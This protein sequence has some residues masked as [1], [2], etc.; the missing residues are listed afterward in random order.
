MTENTTQEEKKPTSQKLRQIGQK[1]QHG[2][3][4]VHRKIG[5]YGWVS[6]GLLLLLI[7]TIAHYE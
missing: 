6:I 3:E 7:A 1:I 4:H 5:I 2:F